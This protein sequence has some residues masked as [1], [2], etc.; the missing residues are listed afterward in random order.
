VAALTSSVS[1]FAVFISTNVS[2]RFHRSFSDKCW[3]WS[4]RKNQFSSCKTYSVTCQLWAWLPRLRVCCLI[5]E[6][7]I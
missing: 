3:T 2:Y 1:L 4:C 5:V 7:W 6:Y